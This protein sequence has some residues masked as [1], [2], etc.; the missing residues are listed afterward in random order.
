MKFKKSVMDTALKKTLACIKFFN[1]KNTTL[2]T[3]VS[4]PS[5]YK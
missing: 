2:T 5:R 1:K 4:I 3:L